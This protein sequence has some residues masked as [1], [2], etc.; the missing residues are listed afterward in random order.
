VLQSTLNTMEE[1]EKKIPFT[2]ALGAFRKSIHHRQS[3]MHQP[4]NLS[5]K[6]YLMKA[7]SVGNF[8]KRSSNLFKIHFLKLLT[9]EATEL[10][11]VNK[12]FIKVRQA[13]LNNHYTCE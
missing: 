6:N 4:F 10:I 3:V 5:Q 7:C 8:T 11:L 12:K 2:H 13:I 1:G 9:W